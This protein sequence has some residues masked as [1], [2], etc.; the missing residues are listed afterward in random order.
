MIETLCEFISI[1]RRMTSDDGRGSIVSFGS[2]NSSSQTSFQERGSWF[3]LHDNAR[4][5]T[6]ISIEQFLAKHGIPEL[7]HP[8]YS[9][10]L[11]PPAFIIPLNQTNTERE[12]V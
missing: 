5:H 6:A 3:L 7:N 2:K 9:P 10:D 11:S 1:D 8:P 4:P 12:K